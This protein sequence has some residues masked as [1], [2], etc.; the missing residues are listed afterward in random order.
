MAKQDVD[1]NNNSIQT[2]F[3]GVF[4]HTVSCMLRNVV[5]F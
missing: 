4:S 3:A 2:Y 1:I 5:S